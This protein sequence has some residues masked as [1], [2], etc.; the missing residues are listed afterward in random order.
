MKMVGDKTT[1]CA[2][3]V[4]LGKVIQKSDVLI[5]DEMKKMLQQ[6]IYQL[7]TPTRLN[8]HFGYF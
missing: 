5:I 8:L 1:L 4:S 6:D 2:S 3:N 7:T